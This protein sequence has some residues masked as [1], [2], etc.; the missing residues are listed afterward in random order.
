ML[1]GTGAVEDEEHL[2]ISCAMYEELRLKMNEGIR[3]KTGWDL[4]AMRGNPHY[5]LGVTIGNVSDKKI[6]PFVRAV[7]VRFIRAALDKR[8]D[9]LRYL[10]TLNET[11]RRAELNTRLLLGG[12]EG[13]SELK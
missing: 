1:C 11:A 12:R 7:V 2:M 13:G 4:A 10:S 9:L 8:S 6:R 3:K 5:V